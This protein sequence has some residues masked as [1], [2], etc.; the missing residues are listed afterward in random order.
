MLPALFFTKKG[1][2]IMRLGIT[3]EDEKGLDGNIAQHFG[4]CKYF[5]LVDIEKNKIKD[6]KIV[7][8]T[9]VHGG[10]GCMT[11]DEL[12]K[13][14]IT[15]VIA[16]G[17]GMNAQNKFVQA[18]VQVFGYSGTAKAAIDDFLKGNLGGLDACKEHGGE[19]S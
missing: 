14:N 2:C 18:G 13:H 5:F 1:R 12:L 19:C 3:L 7:P 17:M 4:Q 8:N 9:I 10:G 16:G 6:S 11:V 15:H